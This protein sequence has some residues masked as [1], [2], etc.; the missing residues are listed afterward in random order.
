VQLSGAEQAT[1]KH[2][3]LRDVILKAQQVLTLQVVVARPAGSAVINQ[4]HGN[5]LDSAHSLVGARQHGIHFQ[6][7]GS[8]RRIISTFRIL[9]DRIG[10]AHREILQRGQAADDGVGYADAPR[11]TSALRGKVAKRQYCER[12]YRRHYRRRSRGR[13]RDRLRGWPRTIVLE[14][15]YRGRTIT[16]ATA[17]P[18]TIFRLGGLVRSSATMACPDSVSR[19]SRCKSVRISAACW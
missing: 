19:F 3:L 18:A 9:E 7:P 2:H 15:S 8:L 16:A 1:L 4:L 10:G 17:T 6:L 11:L 12:S 13:R 14:G 5:A